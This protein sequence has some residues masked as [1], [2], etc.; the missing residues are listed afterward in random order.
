MITITEHAKVWRT[1]LVI[2]EVLLLISLLIW[3]SAPFSIIDLFRLNLRNFEN[4][5]LLLREKLRKICCYF[6]WWFIKGWV[7]IVVLSR[8]LDLLSSCGSWCCFDWRGITVGWHGRLVLYLWVD[9]L[10]GFLF[11]T[12]QLLNSRIYIK[13][14]LLLCSSGILLRFLLYFMSMIILNLHTSIHSALTHLIHD[15]FEILL[16]H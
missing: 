15:I 10:H 4:E 8:L 12:E 1:L 14:G 3:F 11:P 9:K 16:R 7:D 6:I 13:A 2:C 5:V